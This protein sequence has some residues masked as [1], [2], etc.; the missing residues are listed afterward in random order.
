M[1]WQKALWHNALAAACL[2][3]LLLYH[4]M[5]E[6][7]IA[8]IYL[9][10]AATTKLSP[11]VLAAMMPYLED[12]YGN[13]GAMYGPGRSAADAVEKARGQVAMLFGC[14]PDQVVFT[15]GGSE[16]NSMV[17]QGLRHRLT[18]CGKQ[19]LIVSA[20]EHDSVLRSAETLTRD[21]FSITYLQPGPDGCISPKDVEAAIR[22]D[23]GLVS[24]MFVNNETG[25]VNDVGE[26]GRI[27]RQNDVLFHTDCVQAAGQYLLSVRKN[28]ADFAS[29]SAHKFHGPKGV[30]ALYLRERSI[31]PLVSGG[32]AQ[33][34]SLRGGTEN[35]PGIVGLGVAAAIAAADMH[36]D[37][38]KVS[39][40][41]QKF[42]AELVSAFRG[43]RLDENGLHV[44]GRPVIDPGKTLNLR[45]D[46]I[47]AQTLLLM[48]DAKSICIS[49]G[50]ACRS[51]EIEPS[52]VLTAMGLSDA[53]AR[54]AVRFS[55][56]KYNTADEMKEA[57]RNVAACV[58]VLWHS[59]CHRW[60]EDHK[61]VDENA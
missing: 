25:A 20:I 52:H 2:L 58:G 53:E 26:I 18:E 47:D 60:N 35:V 28:D 11:E 41:K 19:H 32:H 37:L 46:G 4:D 10:N 45:F 1:R 39:T 55:F 8:M 9:D 38:I 23:T 29:I 27:C 44:N 3:P 12:E 49:T 56:S 54:S 59:E 34:F 17:F 7:A 50:S 51:Q 24:V 6:E 5:Y 43:M 30:G 36:D 57:A 22:A 61:E 13:A 21:G 48:L 31:S 15:S 40:L 16:S 42:Y 33:E 14:A